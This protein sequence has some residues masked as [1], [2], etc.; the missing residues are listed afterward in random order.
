M[1]YTQDALF[2]VSDLVQPKRPSCPWAVC[3]EE[4]SLAECVDILA[5]QAEELPFD[6][7]GD[8]R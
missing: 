6:E 7:A 8:A 5:T 3:V 1:Q 4:H 2:P